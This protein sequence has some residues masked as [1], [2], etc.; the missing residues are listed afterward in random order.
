[1]NDI[2]LS[3]FVCSCISLVLSLFVFLKNKNN[4]INQSFSFIALLLGSWLMC[5]S[6]PLLIILIH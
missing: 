6:A 1:M 4:K 5:W 2:A 3:Y